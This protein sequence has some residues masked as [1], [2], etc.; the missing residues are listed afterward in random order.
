MRLN[1]IAAV[2]GLLSISAGSA[3]CLADEST[4]TAIRSKRLFAQL[5]F[6]LPE[7]RIHPQGQYYD[8]R[9]RWKSTSISQLLLAVHATVADAEQTLVEHL[10]FSEIPSTPTT[11][12]YGD[13]RLLF[14]T[15]SQTTGSI[16]FRRANVV[17]AFSWKGRLEDGT[18]LAV[19]VDD[20]IQND[21]EVA[22][23][24][25]MTPSPRIVST[26]APD[27]IRLRESIEITPILE[28]LGPSES[29]QMRMSEVGRIQAISRP[30]AGGKLLLTGPHALP[31]PGG[32]VVTH[33]DG[34]RTIIPATQPGAPTKR[35]VLVAANTDNVFV[36][37]YVTIELRE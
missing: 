16:V 18:G 28:G 20:L 7:P 5:G 4:V 8:V 10:L 14:M 17:V 25:T 31:S 11:A 30:V 34:S 13:K 35:Y 24:G 15:E 33:A 3:R 22:P 36:R 23:R 29:V 21:L 27:Q 1:L 32:E 12:A 26:N 2:I 19:R 37:Q 6:H 9:D